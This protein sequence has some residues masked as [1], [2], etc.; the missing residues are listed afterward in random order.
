M[1]NFDAGHYFLTAF[2][3][4]RSHVVDDRLPDSPVQRV[5]DAIDRLPRAWQSPATDPA[6]WKLDV[7]RRFFER[8]GKPDDPRASPFAGSLR[9]HLLR[10]AVLDD[11]IFNGRPP[12]DTL[13]SQAGLRPKPTDPDPADLLPCAYLMFTAD[14]DAVMTPGEKLKDSLTPTEQDR[15]RDDWAREIWT[16]AEGE[17]REIFGNC[18]Q[19]DD[20]TIKTADDF[21]RYVA[22][23]Q[24][25]TYMPFNDYYIDP[26]KVKL[27]P[28][29][30]IA[31]AVAAPLIATVLAFLAWVTGAETWLGYR[32]EQAALVA[33]LLTVAA[34]YGGYRFAM[35]HGQKPWPAAEFGDLPSVLKGLYIQQKF[36]GFVTRSYDMSPAEL[37][38]AFGDFLTA[39]APEELFDK[40]Q[41]PGVVRSE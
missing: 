32:P 37:R 16:L 17:L 8:I 25:E 19:F 11:A 39:H 29:K 26:P 3:P 5:R 9:T 18:Q 20:E 38:G 41:P 13:L 40:T 28:V 7:N 27:L 23:C 15:V 35:A 33:L 36:A 6:I 4:I 22:R 31:A 30:A 14:F 24:V 12:S 1:P 34:I 21:A 2:A 10:F